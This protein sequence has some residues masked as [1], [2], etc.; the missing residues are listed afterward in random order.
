LSADFC[1]ESTGGAPVALFASSDFGK[2][3]GTAGAGSGE[4]VGAT[5][6]ADGVT[7]SWPVFF[8]SR[9]FCKDT[10]EAMMMT[11]MTP[12]ASSLPVCVSGQTW[13]IEP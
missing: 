10:L 9:P 11:P 8:A 13:L 12:A 7:S 5:S 4:P 2:G 6:A 1:G 3:A